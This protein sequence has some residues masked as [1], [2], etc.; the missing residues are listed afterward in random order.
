MSRT[1]PTP[2]SP[3]FAWLT[4]G[5]ALFT[6]AT[7]CGPN[8]DG[9]SGA[10]CDYDGKTYEAGG[11]FPATDGCNTCFCDED[12]YVGCTEMGCTCDPTLICT[13]VLTCIQGELYPTGCGPANC[14]APIGPC[15]GACDPTLVCDLAITCVDGM[16]YPTG[17]G[18]DNCDA[19]IGP[20]DG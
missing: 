20:C 4:L 19:P 8:R 17:C 6:L 10:T 18:P 3:R 1:A 14:D 13:Q 9:G 2:R 15:D 16:L 7:A 12:G 11:P 5:S